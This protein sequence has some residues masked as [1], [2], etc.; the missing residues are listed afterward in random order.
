MSGDTIRHKVKG[1]ELPEFFRFIRE[2]GAAASDLV[3]VC[4]GTDRSTGDSLGPLVGTMLTESGYRQVIGT[5]E[6]P[7]DASNLIMRLKEIPSGKV[8]I[9]IDACL[10]LPSSIGSFQV[11]NQPIQPGKSVGKMLPPV[12]EYSIAAIVNADGPKQYW[13]LQSTSLYRVMGMAKEIVAAVR[14]VFPVDRDSHPV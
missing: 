13:N 9:A 4:I 5:L 2:Q 8:T 1:D 12:G 7:C 14:T 11:A 3:F 6:S 10:G